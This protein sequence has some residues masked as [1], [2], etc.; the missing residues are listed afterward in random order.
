MQAGRTTFSALAQYQFDKELADDREASSAISD[1][2]WYISQATM[3]ALLA[4][5]EK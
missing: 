3:Y 1:N 2:R 5:L 4:L